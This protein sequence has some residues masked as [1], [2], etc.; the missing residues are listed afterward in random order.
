MTIIQPSV[1]I[2]ADRI[3]EAA[4]SAY[5]TLA[6]EPH[7]ERKDRDHA[8]WLQQAAQS[9]APPHEYRR[10]SLGESSLVIEMAEVH[11]ESPQYTVSLDQPWILCVLD[12]GVNPRT[13]DGIPAWKA[14]EVPP[15][16]GVVLRAGLW[17]GP[18]SPVRAADI[19]TVFTE[20]TLKTGSDWVDLDYRVV[21][22]P[23]RASSIQD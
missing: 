14:F 13:F 17:H 18:V 19:F 5:G 10:L 6:S 20:G 16:V 9:V 1:E 23:L 7:P 11:L 21:V 4:F 3:S 22:V 12:E 15:R 8:K 2:F